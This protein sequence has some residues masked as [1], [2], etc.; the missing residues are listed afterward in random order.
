LARRAG[1]RGNPGLMRQLGA[2]LQALPKT[3][4]AEVARQGAPVCTE[5]AQGAF[6]SGQTVYGDARPQGVDGGE[7]SLVKSGSVRG[8]LR[9]VATGTQIRCQYGPKHMRY[10]IGK[11][12]ILPNNAIP[13][14]WR[15]RL[16]EITRG[17]LRAELDAAMAGVARKAG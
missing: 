2:K 8:S 3:L 6:D 9:F 1:L 17:V 11:Y 4:Q 12:K 7:L 15:A 16:D 5:L 10:L 13:F 14:R